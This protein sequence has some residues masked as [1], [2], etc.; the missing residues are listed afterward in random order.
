MESASAQFL[1]A[2]R[3]N[4]SQI[5]WARRLGYRG[6]PITDWERG[7]NFPTAEEALRVA[8]RGGSDV[9]SAFQEFDPKLPL[10]LGEDGAFALS[11]WLR[12]LCASKR[13]TLLARDMQASR[14]SVSR[15]LSG[16]AKPRL[17]EFLRLV[18]A[19]TGRVHDLVAALV[20]IDSVP[21]LVPLHDAANAAKR[22]AF[23]AP[24]TEAILRVLDTRPPSVV[25]SSPISTAAWIAGVLGLTEAE[26]D[27]ALEHLARA[28][29]VS[30]DG[31]RYVPHQ[32]LSVDTRGGKHA[33]RALKVHWA[34][35]A[36]KRAASPLPE[37][38][39]GYN[40]I[41]VSDADLAR[42]RELLAN[43]Y[44]EIRSIVAVSE[45]AE[46]VALVNL[47]LVTW[48]SPELVDS[49]SQLPPTSGAEIVT[50]ARPD[51]D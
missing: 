9:I 28:G 2:L 50:N 15:W 25:N 48:P 20:P 46:R 10:G 4:R 1:R 45:P 38:V 35:V 34:D 26:C 32:T 13:V 21:A 44:R 40:V 11:D 42:I 39:F 23:D 29:L 51:I 8:A 24:W 5:A 7:R 18:N 30:R 33:V 19:A 12:R 49:P 14:S 16:H 31:D 6:N 27:S 17:P 47:H 43:T 3:A 37:D 22:L 36:T 41:S